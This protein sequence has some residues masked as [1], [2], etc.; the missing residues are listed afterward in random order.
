GDEEVMGV[1][2]EVGGEDGRE[3]VLGGRGGWWVV[4]REVEMCEGVVGG[5]VWGGFAGVV[6][7][8]GGVGSRC[9]GWWCMWR[10][11]GMVWRGW[12]RVGERSWVGSI[13][14]S[15]CG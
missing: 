7:V 10:R 14:V 4:V 11:M 9:G 8:K 15:F 13:G 1:G 12:R 2:T 5:E 3:V 6:R